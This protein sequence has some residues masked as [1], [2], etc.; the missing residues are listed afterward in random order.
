M[1]RFDNNPSTYIQNRGAVLED[2]EESKHAPNAL[3]DILYGP[4]TTNQ[5]IE[6]APRPATS[7]LSM[8]RAMHL[9]KVKQKFDKA[10]V[11]ASMEF[12]PNDNKFSPS[13]GSSGVYIKPKDVHPEMTDEKVALPEKEGVPE[14]TLNNEENIREESLTASLIKPIRMD[15]PTANPHIDELPADSPQIG[16]NGRMQFR[17]EVPDH[18]TVVQ[19]R[20]LPAPPQAEAE[21]VERVLPPL[22]EDFGAKFMELLSDHTAS[23]ETT[24]SLMMK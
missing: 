16:A 4:T 11:Y 5:K 6:E 1:R 20:S 15:I 14:P 23:L 7:Q 17:N 8:K 18:E 22:P 24:K 9:E 13:K 19:D 2:E 3:D 21:I 10:G 12:K